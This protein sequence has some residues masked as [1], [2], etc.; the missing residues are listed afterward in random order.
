LLPV[1]Q[2][3]PTPALPF[4]IPFTDHVTVVSDA[5]VTFALNDMR[6][7]VETVAVGGD[8]V[9][10]MLLVTV[11]LADSTVGPPS[12][13]PLAVAWIVTGLVAG[14]FAGAV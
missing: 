6:W 3:W 4:A 1:T 5:F 2:T 7:P 13:T 14:M 11:T 12:V 9:T 10:V 8:T